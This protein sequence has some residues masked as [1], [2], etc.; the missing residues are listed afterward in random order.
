MESIVLLSSNIPVGWMAGPSAGV[1][2]AKARRRKASLF[3]GAMGESLG[4]RGGGF[5]TVLGRGPCLRA[6]CGLRPPL[7]ILLHARPS[8]MDVG[9]FLGSGWS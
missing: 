9:S 1:S 2:K 3:S 8:L 4:V 5:L 6:R 7:S